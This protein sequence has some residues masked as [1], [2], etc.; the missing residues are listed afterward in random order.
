MRKVL[1]ILGQLRDSDLQWL[2]DAG[3]P[4]DVEP[5]EVLIR[6]G[7]PIDSLFVVVQGELG[8]EKAGTELARLSA[9]EVVGEMS[10]LDGKPPNATVS[11]RAPA[12]VHAIARARLRAKLAADSDFAARFYKALGVFLA[13]RLDRTDALIGAGPRVAGELP[14][15]DQ[16][17]ISPEVLDNV[18][19]AGTR[20]EWF[21]ERLGGR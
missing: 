12:R 10:F 8:V 20:F 13:G 9:G 21:L 14:D 5:G 1:Y 19:L 16:D 6:E 7:E 17:A 4:R 18:V 2:V 3:T 15:P 11:A